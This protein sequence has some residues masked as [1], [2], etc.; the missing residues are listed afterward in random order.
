MAGAAAGA[1]ARAAEVE[2]GQA[3]CVRGAAAAAGSVPPVR[4]PD[5]HAAGSAAFARARVAEASPVPSPAEQGKGA[6]EAAESPGAVAGSAATAAAVAGPAATAWT[7]AQGEAA[8]SGERAPPRA[9]AEPEGSARQI[10]AMRGAPAI[11]DP[12]P[13]VLRTPL[14]RIVLAALPARFPMG[15]RRASPPAPADAARRRRRL[16]SAADARPGVGPTTYGQRGHAVR[17]EPGQREAGL[18]AANR[19]AS[20]AARNRA[21]DFCRVSSYSAAGSLSATTPAPA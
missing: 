6:P 17:R 16:L 9:P 7:R 15:S 21:R 13:A 18:P 19:T 1:E 12:W 2:R 4:A 10:A 5:P 20:S 3:T 8:A 14:P 11:S